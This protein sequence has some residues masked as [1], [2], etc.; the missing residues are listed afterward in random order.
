MTTIGNLLGNKADELAKK[1]LAI[2]D[3]HIIQMGKKD[4]I[5]PKEGNLRNKFFI[6]LGFDN[7]GNIIGGVVINS[8]IN[9]NLPDNVT[10]YLMPISKK[11]FPFLEHDSFVNCSR[12]KTVSK[13][14]FSRETYR[15]RVEDEETI[16]LII[17]TVCESPYVN[18]Y[19]L[20]EF[21]IIK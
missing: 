8:S 4:G 12:L 10:D 17:G 19:Q 1:F 18:K 3:V 14:K 6:I 13:E 11:Q 20:K 2:G 15:G 21:G 16:N 9:Y 5:T 7:N